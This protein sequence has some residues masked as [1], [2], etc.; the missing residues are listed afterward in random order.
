MLRIEPVRSGPSRPYGRLSLS[1]RRPG[2]GDTV[3]LATGAGCRQ[4]TLNQT[5]PR[6]SS[7]TYQDALSWQTKTPRLGDTAT[8]LEQPSVTIKSS[9]KAFG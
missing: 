3:Q 5:P 2:D 4:R 6:C 1:F 7:S 8:R 9:G